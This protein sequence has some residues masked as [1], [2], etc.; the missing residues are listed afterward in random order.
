MTM[1]RSPLPRTF[2]RLLILAAAARACV[3]Q[4]APAADAAFDSYICMLETRLAGQ[5]HSHASFVAATAPASQFETRLRQGDVIVENIAPKGSDL[6]GALLHHWRGTALIPGTGAA[7]FDH[8]LRD[9]EAYPH[10]FAPQ[11]LQAKASSTS[12]DQFQ[13]SMRIRQKHVLVVVMDTTY[14]V[15]FGTLDPQ[16][17]YSISHSTRIA[18]IASAGTADEHS[19]KPSEA[20]GFLWRQNTYWTYEERD[21]GLYIQIESVS[22]TRSIPSGFGW[23]LRPFVES[24]PRDTVEFTLRAARNALLKPDDS[25]RQMVTHK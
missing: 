6:P 10:F 3:A 5:H 12:T 25:S 13:A 14:D 4:P 1:S 19:L 7:D 20:H 2:C 16:H 18:E 22:L 23:A 9:F 15:D 17:R 11:V 8:L 24:V 21:G